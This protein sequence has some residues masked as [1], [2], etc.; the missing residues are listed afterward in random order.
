[1]RAD[2]INGFKMCS[3]SAYCDDSQCKPY[4]NNED[5]IKHTFQCHEIK[6]QMKKHEGSFNGMYGN[7]TLKRAAVTDFIQIQN[8]QST[9]LASGTYQGHILDT[10]TLASAGEAGTKLFCI[11]SV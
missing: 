1:M 10:A 4:C 6:K 8:I 2:T 7:V 5:S 11:F 9:V 3:A